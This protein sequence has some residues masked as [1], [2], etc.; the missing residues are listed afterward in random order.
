MKSALLTAAFL[1]TGLS[2][3]AGDKG[4]GGYSIVCRDLNNRITSAEILDIYEGRILYRRNYAVDQNSV[5]DLIA[6]AKNKVSQF[7]KFSDKLNK[8]I[9][10]IE[11]NIVF[12]PEGN[13]LQETDDAFPVIKKKGC[14][15]EQLANYTDAGELF[16]SEEIYEELDNVN[17]AALIIHEA[18][19]SMR[20]KA[21]GEETSQ[22]TRRLVAQLFALNPDDA[23]ID[24]WVNDT[25][26]RPNNQ[27]PCGLTGT[28]EE[29]IESCSYVQTSVFSMTLVTRTKD[30][31]EVWFDG[32]KKI[33]W[34]D[35]IPEKMNFERAKTAC[36][37]IASEGGNL[38]DINWKLPSAEDYNSAETLINVLPN[39]MRYSEAYWFWTTSTKGRMV[40][41]FNG[42]DGTINWNPF[43]GSKSGSVRCVS[44]Q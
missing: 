11:K 8:E 25:L 41:T 28:I 40:K 34:S 16:V 39:M 44:H 4:N 37:M 10:L 36:E 7:A 24:R 1:L 26:Y 18:V 27:R 20:R 9:A 43:T 13:E 12:I 42:Q 6:V 19:Y 33:L 2:A 32:H 5:E 29:R 3:F 17:K 38:P 15:F 23:V 21:L 22:N 31:K 30:Q 35:R 14:K